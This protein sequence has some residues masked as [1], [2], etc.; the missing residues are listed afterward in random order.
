MY[1]VCN[2]MTRSRWMVRMKLSGNYESGF[3]FVAFTAAGL[4]Y[5]AELVE[6]YASVA[7][8]VIRVLI[9]VSEIAGMLEF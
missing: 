9:L 8:K 2:G 3:I 1:V 4:Y 7:C 6:E 5:L